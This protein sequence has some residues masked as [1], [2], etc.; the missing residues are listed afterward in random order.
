MIRT[1][2][3]EDLTLVPLP[4]W[5]QSPRALAA[6]AVLAA[7]LAVGVW[8]FRRWLAQRPAPV[9]ARATEPDRTPEFLER[10]EVLRSR[11]DQMSPH[12]FA[13]E[14]SDVLREY[15]EWR[16][17][18]AIRFQTTHEFLEAAAGSNVLSP[19]QRDSLGEYLGFCDLVKFARQ[20]ATPEEELRLVATASA[21]VQQ[22]GA[23]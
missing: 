8:M 14:C 20:G 15:V 2:L 6:F 3:I 19:A 4:P 11:R 7:V 23:A 18:L 9:A 16:H 10:L 22:G 1:N 17:R 12:D 21:F 5:W 13:L